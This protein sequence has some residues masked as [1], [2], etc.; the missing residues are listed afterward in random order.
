MAR[1]APSALDCDR[2]AISDGQESGHELIGVSQVVDDLAGDD[3]ACIAA[4]GVGDLVVPQ[5]VHEG[6]GAAGADNTHGVV[7]V[8][9]C[10]IQVTVEDNHVVAA[11]RHTG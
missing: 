1:E 10:L 11:R 6:D 4:C 7:Q 5:G 9:R 3:G 2:Q 8:L